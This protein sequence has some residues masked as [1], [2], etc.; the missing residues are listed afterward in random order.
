[1][2]RIAALV[3]AV[4]LAT[5]Y[6]SVALADA[7]TDVTSPAASDPIPDPVDTFTAAR[8]AWASGLYTLAVVLVL[9]AIARGIY[10]AAERWPDNPVVVGLG[11]RHTK[12]RAAIIG[13][14][15]VLG[16]LTAELGNTGGINWQVIGGA[17]GAAVALYLRPEPKDKPATV[18]GPPAVPAQRRL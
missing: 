10:Y 15:S 3:L 1:M 6:A 12:V 13:T 9:F 11:L 2:R 14:V 7:T 5:S 16:A 8:T 18:A 4:T 17:A